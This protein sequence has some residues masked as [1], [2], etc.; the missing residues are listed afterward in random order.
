MSPILHLSLYPH[1]WPCD[2]TTLSTK[3]VESIY[4]LWFGTCLVTC[5][6]QQ[7]EAKVVLCWFSA[8]YLKKFCE[9]LLLS[10]LHHHFWTKRCIRNTAELVTSSYNKA[11]L[12]Q[13]IASPPADL[14]AR[15]EDQRLSAA[16]EVLWLIFTPHFDMKWSEVTQSSPT[17]CEPMDYSPPGSSVHGIF[18]ARILEWV[19]ISFSRGSSQPRDRTQLSHSAGR[20][21]NLWATREAQFWHKL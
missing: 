19:A 8:F 17:L 6:G 4:H 2:F 10:H 15:H 3:E 16:D 11:C 18:Q 1:C 13:P 9:L 12:D 5:F 20:H 14:W 21:F 7:N